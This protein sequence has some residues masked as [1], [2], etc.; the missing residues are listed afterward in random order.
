[1]D[2]KDEIKAF[3]ERAEKLKSQISTEEATKNA[4]IMPFIKALGYDVFNPLEVVPEYVADIGIKKGEKVDYAILRDG[5]PSI[6][7]ECK[8]WSE[9]LD[10]HNSQLFRYFHTT[11]AKFGILSNGIIYR[12]YTDLVEPNKMDEKPFLEF[13]VTDIKDNQIEELK[14]FHKSYFDVDNIVNTA[15]ELKYMTELKAAIHTEF[16]TPTENFVRHFGKQIYSGV[17]TAK[18]MEQFTALT[19]KSIQQYINDIITERLKSALKKENDGEL[20]SP[21]QE[22]AMATVLEK[23]E[24]KIETTDEEMEAFLIVKT[25]LR[26][27]ISASR[28]AYRDNQSY[29][30][31]LLDDNNRKTICRLY[32]NGQKKYFAIIDEQ[33]KEV[34]TEIA[35]ID[36]IFNFTETLN[37]IVSDFDGEKN[38][39]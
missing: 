13:N 4:F 34:K 8:H 25:I 1:M 10:V 29:F 33:K 28:V 22:V 36:D 38:G 6:F 23:T 20:I 37:K 7:V 2:F 21:E 19:K 31:I 15:S 17:L 11:K 24:S 32:L 30:A 12:F 35:T 18:V 9:N 39:S 27:K 5:Q 26:Q 16:Q 3:G 14:K